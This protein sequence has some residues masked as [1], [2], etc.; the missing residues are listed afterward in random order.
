[1]E[2]STET[3]KSFLEAWKL[4]DYE[5]MHT[6]CNKTYKVGHT[7]NQVKALLPNRI[8]SYKILE[9]NPVSDVM[10]DVTV[11]IRIQG[12]SKKCTARLLCETVP[13]KPSIDGEWGVNPISITKMA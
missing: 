1:M 10:H 3:V 5:K 2:K 6:L 8:K 7:K 13:F 12:K 9:T 4:Q 11:S